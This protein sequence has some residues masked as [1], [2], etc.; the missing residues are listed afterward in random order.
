MVVLFGGSDNPSSLN[1]LSDTWEWNGITWTQRTPVA[2][3]PGRVYHAMAYDSA[4]GVTVVFGGISMA[5]G[6]LMADT[7]EWNGTNWTQRTPATSPPVRYAHAMVFDSARGV[8]VLFGGDPF[9]ISGSGSPLSDTWE[10]NG[11]NWTQRAPATPPPGR[12]LH[13]MA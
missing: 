10:W 2:A 6:G 8:T 1:C 3:P 4:R 5:G 7:W 9:F 13:A 12:Y 11:T